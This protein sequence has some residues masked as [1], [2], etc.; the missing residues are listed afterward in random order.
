VIRRVPGGVEARARLQRVETLLDQALDDLTGTG[1]KGAV[2][3]TRC[4]AAL[5]EVAAEL[6]SFA[7]LLT[8]R[9]Q[10]RS[11]LLRG[12]NCLEAGDRAALSPQIKALLPRLTRLERLLAAAAEFYRGWCAAGPAPGYPAP[13]YETDAWSHSPALLTLEG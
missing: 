6:Q 9:P 7:G 1:K 11:G 8:E 4:A 12:Q 13:G 10:E 5:T 2:P 3:C